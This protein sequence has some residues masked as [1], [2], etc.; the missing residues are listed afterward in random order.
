MDHEIIGMINNLFISVKNKMDELHVPEALSDI[1][2]LVQR[3]NKYIDETKPWALAKNPDN[4]ERLA[5]VLYN[6]SEAIRV[7]AV[8]L[9]PFI[10]NSSKIIL[11]FRL[12]TKFEENTTFSKLKGGD[13]KRQGPISLNI[14]KKELQN[15]EEE[16]S[17]EKKSLRLQETL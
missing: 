5:T 4:R 17:T 10:P 15:M 14:K 9:S 12:K 11:E 16:E 7:I 2:T 1:W 13:R 3:A 8:M 6:L